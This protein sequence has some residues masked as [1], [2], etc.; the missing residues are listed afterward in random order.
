MVNDSFIKVENVFI[1]PK[2]IESLLDLQ[3]ENYG[4]GNNFIYD[5]GGI[6][7]YEEF[8]DTVTE[9]ILDIFHTEDI[10]DKEKNAMDALLKLRNVKLLI[11]S[12]GVPDLTDQKATS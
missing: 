10:S 6:K 8:L 9:F 2:V 3:C 1:T 12:F 5:N 4:N 11:R 7:M